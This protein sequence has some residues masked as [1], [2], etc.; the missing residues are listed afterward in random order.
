MNIEQFFEQFF[1]KDFISEYNHSNYINQINGKQYF[2]MDCSG[3]VYWCLMQMGYTRA[4]AELRIFL[5]QNS[6]I[7]INRFYC[8]DFSFIYQH[9]QDFK[10]WNFLTSP[11]PD[12]ILIVLFPDENGHCMFVKEIINMD[13]NKMRLRVIDSTRYAHKNDTRIDSTGIGI[14]EIEI[15]F[16]NGN[17]FYDSCNKSLPTRNAEI[18]FVSP[19]K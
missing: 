15:S 2:H 3:F 8:K 9:K 18:Y 14:G 13:N 6:F 12:C 7:K 16:K 19:I 5:R 11:L 17:Y 1:K 10:Y 4:L